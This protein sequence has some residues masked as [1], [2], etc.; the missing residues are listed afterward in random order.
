MK[1]IELEE[2]LHSFLTLPN[3][4]VIHFVMLISENDIHTNPL[5]E[6]R[7]LPIIWEDV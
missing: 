3:M 7:R 4:D 5:R 6:I 2:Q 1:D